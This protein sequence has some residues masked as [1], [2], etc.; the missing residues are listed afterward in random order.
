[1]VHFRVYLSFLNTGLRVADTSLAVVV[2]TAFGTMLSSMK[3]SLMRL[4]IMF[5]LT[6]A[7]D[8]DQRTTPEVVSISKLSSMV[9]F[10]GLSEVDGNVRWM[11]G[12]NLV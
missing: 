4:L 2:A 5:A 6:G 9:Y 3:I 8:L 12:H 10:V 11:E 1:M 7:Y